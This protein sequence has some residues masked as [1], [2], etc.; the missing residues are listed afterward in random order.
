MKKNILINILIACASFLNAQSNYPTVV[1][2]TNYGTM[3]AVLYDDTPE[4]SR[5]YLDLINK[6]YFNGTL[7]HRVVKD[8][9]IQGGA[10]DSRNAPAGTQIGSGRRDMELA[11]EFC[12]N[13]Y[14]KK[15]ALAAP[16]RGNNE[17]PQ[18]KSDASQLYI[19]HGQIYSEGQL[20]TLEMSVNVPIKNEL[21]RTHYNPAKDELNRLKEINDRH[22][23]NNL[24]DSV[25]GVVDSLYEIA[26]GKHFFPKNLK[27][28]YTALGGLL[29]LD[30]EYTVFGEVTEGL[31]V[32]DNIAALS[33]D[34]HS[35]PTTDV[36]II[37]IYTE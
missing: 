5:H 20:D 18:K 10:Q 23:F 7:F 2:E 22:G 8:F 26:P 33:V 17:N 15:G 36:K 1:I 28:D 30:S 12:E 6:G 37:R 34:E 13:R 25:L 4:H 32:I 3:K 35:R 9:V 21:I 29:H 24:L 16:R 19:V 27:E 31:Q 14:H 11:P